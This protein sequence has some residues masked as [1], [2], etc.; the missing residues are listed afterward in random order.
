MSERIPDRVREEVLK[1]R[2]L[3]NCPNM[4]DINAVMRMAFD[5]GLYHLVDYLQ[6]DA[7]RAVY[8]T[9]IMYGDRQ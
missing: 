7:N 2:T 9:F 8:A 1:L 3:D 5:N 4:F 6:S